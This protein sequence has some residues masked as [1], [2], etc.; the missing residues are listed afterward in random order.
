MKET[1]LQ[2]HR[3]LATPYWQQVADI[4]TAGGA[5]A[6]LIVTSPQFAAMLGGGSAPVVTIQNDVDK[7]EVREKLKEARGK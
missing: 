2:L 1:P 5:G 3:V 4:S 7:Q 6:D